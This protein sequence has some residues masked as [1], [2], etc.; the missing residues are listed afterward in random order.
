MKKLFIIAA[1]S[2]SLLSTI[3]QQAMTLT[4]LTAN[5]VSNVVAQ[6][7]IIDNFTI[8]NSTT[9]NARVDFFDAATAVTNYTQAAYTK[10][11]TYST[12]FN[13]V[14]TNTTGVL[15][16][17]TFVGLYTA[18][19]A[20]TSGSIARAKVA[21]LVIPANSTLNKDVKLQ[22]VLGLTAVPDQSLTLITTYRTP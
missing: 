8:L 2:L 22:T 19:E 3:G 5:T 11:V 4:S 6:A 15:V 1:L 12:N 16:T 14:F 13:V 17:N 9:N 18:P 10:Y 7:C 20:G 21:S